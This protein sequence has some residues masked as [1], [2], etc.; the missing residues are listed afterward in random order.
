VTLSPFPGHGPAR[1]GDNLASLPVPSARTTLAHLFPERRERDHGRAICADLFVSTRAVGRVSINSDMGS[2]PV[3]RSSAFLSHPR[4][5]SR[6]ACAGGLADLL[7]RRGFR[8]SQFVRAV[9]V[10]RHL[11]SVRIHSASRVRQNPTPRTIEQLFHFHSLSAGSTGLVAAPDTHRSSERKLQ[12]V[13]RSVSGTPK[14][15]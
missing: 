8:R 15:L 5:P 12:C 9:K 6:A 14:C 4:G 13:T 7:P 3:V 2:K 11:F 1:K 10:A